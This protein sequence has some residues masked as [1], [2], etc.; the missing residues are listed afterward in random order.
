MFKTKIQRDC[1]RTMA[2]LEREFTVMCK[3]V[4]ELLEW[5]GDNV[6]ELD[7]LYAKV[8]MKVLPL[9]DSITDLRKINIDNMK[10]TVMKIL[11]PF[12]PLNLS[13]DTCLS[14][15]RDMKRGDLSSITIE[16][17]ELSFS[18]CRMI[19]KLERKDIVASQEFELFA[20][21]M[22]REIKEIM[23]EVNKFVTDKGLF[24]KGE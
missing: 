22:Q 10:A 18:D 11:E 12:K 6:R 9:Y 2:H 13:M 19:S 17:G 8:A 5:N 14:I 21:E 1:K 20:F 24:F 15:Y 16:R 4:N 23:D 3:P 7:D